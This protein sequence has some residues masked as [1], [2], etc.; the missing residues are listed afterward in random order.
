MRFATDDYQDLS[1]RSVHPF[2]N[3]LIRPLIALISVL[4][5]GD[6]LYAT[7]I[8]IAL[9]G[10]LCVFLVWYF[11]KQVTH[12]SLYSTL[13]A[14]VFGSSTS[15]LIFGSLIETYILLAATALIF[16]ILLLKDK[17][18]YT[19]VI[20][21]LITFGIT[22]L[23]FAHNVFAHLLVKRD[24]KQLI[25]YG[26]IVAVLV[27]PLNLVNNFIYPDKHPYIW[28]LSAY[29][30]EEKHT[31]PP[32]FQRAH[33]LG[34]VMF[35]H[36]VVAP[37]PLLIKIGTPL[38]QVWLFRAA[39]R[40]APMLIAEYEGWFSSGVAYLWF[41]FMLLGGVL[42]LK[43]LLRQDNRFFFTFI[44]TLVFFFILHMS[45][46]RD[47]FLYSANWTYAIFLFLAL[48]WR[49]LSDKRWFQLALLG[50]IPLLLLN[51]SRLILFMFTA[52][53]ANMR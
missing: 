30:Q 31:F 28:D 27:V 42:F 16:I 43:N 14:A 7:Y 8:L 41:A 19:L 35:L 17:P 44:L 13:I 4:L 40:K 3:I 5:K 24:I 46:G 49:E 37:E 9:T 6:T 38:L 53:I 47:V 26:L 29:G 1:R 25:K 52:S 18:Q 2:I 20:M 10:S 21:G 34:R 36:S 11:V 33:Y 32:N 48:A 45:Y 39:I 23:N 51:N 12:N 22:F 15:Q 50:F